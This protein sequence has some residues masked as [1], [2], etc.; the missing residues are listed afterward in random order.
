MTSRHHR[1]R[2]ALA[3]VTLLTL[4]LTVAPAFAAGK[5]LGAESPEK[6][7][8]RMRDAAEK[9]DLRE[10]AA[11]LAPE[12]RRELAMGMWLASTMM[13]GMADAMGGM[14]IGMGEEMAEAMGAEE[15]AAQ[16]QAAQAKKELDA[17]LAGLK[18]RYD[19]LAKKHGLPALSDEE[20][21][22]DPE[23][24]FAKVDAVEVTGDYF[25]L[26]KGIADATGETDTAPKVS[27]DQLTDLVI[28]GDRASG[29]LG[30][31]PI[32][33]VKLEGRWYVAEMPKRKDNGPGE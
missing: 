19:A 25:D 11:C 12:P 14:A 15:K 20:P 4:L 30:A 10:L 24:L 22:G 28:D 13:I 17:K 8:E 1:N 33:F 3:F 2:A 26:L 7:V 9:E 27:A 32:K 16:E 23:A 29:R 21:Q 6:V 18:L 5:P 31:E